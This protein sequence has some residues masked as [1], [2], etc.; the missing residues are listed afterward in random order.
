[1]ENMGDIFFGRCDAPGIFTDEDIL[2]PFGEPEVYLF[3]DHF[4]FDDIDRDMGVNEAENI[5]VDGD[6]II[7]FDDVLPSHTFRRG[8]Y[9]KGHGVR[10]LVKASQLKILIPCPALM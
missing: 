8:V 9:H 3:A 4:V 7:D 10:G 6:G 2:H 5:E 1:M